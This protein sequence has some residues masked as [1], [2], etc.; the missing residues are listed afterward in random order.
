VTSGTLVLA[1]IIAGSVGATYAYVATVLARRADVSPEGR[2]AMRLFVLWWAMLGVNLFAGGLTYV[3]AGTVG[4]SLAWQTSEALLQR[5]LL[6]ASLVGLMGYMLYV[7][8]GRTRVVPLGAVYAAYF[9]WLVYGLVQ[10]EPIA[11]A[12]YRWRTD[13]VYAKPPN[14]V[15]E[16]A[17][18]LLIVLPPVVASVAYLRLLPNAPSVSQRWRISVVASAI[19]VW[20]VVAVLAGQPG[21][22]DDEPVQLAGRALS[23]A[24]ALAVLA[25]FHP[26]SW[27]RR[28]YGVE[29][30]A[31]TS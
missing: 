6:A 30:Y 4:V 28:R 5:L 16:V 27:V 19:L 31:S 10:Q 3:L 21:L 20:W 9:V 22:L 8:S 14:P 1:G 23:V 15:G 24:T 7:L 17:S 18:F 12:S 26:P 2:R 25:A 11:V 29:G 13:L